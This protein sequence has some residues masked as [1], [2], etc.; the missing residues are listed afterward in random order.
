MADKKKILMVDDDAF[1]TSI[2]TNT[3]QKHGCETLSARD[4]SSGIELAR[5]EHPDLILLDMAMVGMDGFQTLAALK[6]DPATA[7]IPV[8]I[9]SGSAASGDTEKQERA[10]KAGAVDYLE[11]MQF[12]P[13]QLWERV[14]QLLDR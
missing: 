9:F 1:F 12:T 6:K 2:I 8:I 13:E 14:R 3:F 4:G 11:K 5:K 7:S 10:K